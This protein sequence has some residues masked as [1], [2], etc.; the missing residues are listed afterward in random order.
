MSSKRTKEEFDKVVSEM[1]ELYIKEYENGKRWYIKDL[2][3]KFDLAHTT[4][5]RNL[6]DL[7]PRN[8]GKNIFRINTH[9]QIEKKTKAI[10]MFYSGA[11][12][13]EIFEAF[14]EDNPKTISSSWLR[15]IKG[16][17]AEK[18]KQDKKDLARK[19]YLRGID[20][21]EI[22]KKLKVHET[23]LRYFWLKDL[24][25]PKKKIQNPRRDE[26]RRLFTEEKLTISEIIKKFPGYNKNT[27]KHK[28]LGNL[29]KEDTK[30]KELEE[31]ENIISYYQSELEKGNTP[32]IT[33]M[34]EKFNRCEE[35]ISKI[36]RKYIPRAPKD[37]IYKI[38]KNNHI[39][40]YLSAKIL[41]NVLESSAEY[42]S[43][44]LNRKNVKRILLYNA[45]GKIV[46]HYLLDDTIIKFPNFKNLFYRIEKFRNSKV[47]N[48]KPHNLSENEFIV[49]VS[50]VAYQ[51]Q[52]KHKPSLQSLK[53]ILDLY[54]ITSH[55]IKTIIQRLKKLNYIKESD[56]YYIIIK[57]HKDLILK[58]GV[59]YD[60]ETWGMKKIYY[61]REFTD[62]AWV[63]I[64]EKSG[65]I[66]KDA[67]IINILE[68][69]SF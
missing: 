53:H 4:I 52:T 7:P 18:E 67:I 38:K 10:D 41:E 12:Y 9:V 23:T 1:R 56:K 3:Q 30:K 61:P 69:I 51:E 6:K 19:M 27:I 33:L 58:K 45:N 17:R 49:L 50:I 63:L 2:A 31:K 68:H 44:V 47:A 26:A 64:E 22:V 42:I 11:S 65:T 48:F 8:L 57:G 20:V 55:K 43:R 39:Q 5:R 35:Y 16:K 62:K 21:K 14:P 40:I 13:Q 36:I 60:P 29:L 32:L 15:G 46:Y 34:S 28:W 54:S 25:I 66:R 37:G 59:C 24:K